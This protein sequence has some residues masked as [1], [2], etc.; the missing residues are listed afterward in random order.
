MS[1]DVYTA[2]FLILCT[3]VGV[4]EHPEAR[5]GCYIEGFQPRIRTKLKLR[6][7]NSLTMATE[8]AKQLED[9]F[10]SLSEIGQPSTSVT[11][12]SIQRST[13][14]AS[15][16]ERDDTDPILKEIADLEVNQSLIPEFEAIGP[17]TN[18]DPL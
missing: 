9:Y 5:L 7:I 2:K 14:S 16:E 10:N 15:N 18:G 4:A 12:P 13:E 3:R 1:V 6:K 17:E 8:Y 11:T